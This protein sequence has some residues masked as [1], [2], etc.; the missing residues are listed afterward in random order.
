MSCHVRPEL[1]SSHIAD[2]ITL[3][4]F[5]EPALIFVFMVRYSMLL[6]LRSVYNPNPCKQVRRTNLIPPD[7][8]S[9]D[10]ARATQVL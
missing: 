2:W 7:V 6:S 5:L 3:I 8:Y 4:C 1:G 9:S 10:N